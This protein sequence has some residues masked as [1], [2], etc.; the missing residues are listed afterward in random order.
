[1]TS[2]EMREALKAAVEPIST[3]LK[4]LNGRFDA[5][6]IT[7]VRQLTEIHSDLRHLCGEHSKLEEEVDTIRGEWPIIAAHVRR[8]DEATASARMLQPT[9]KRSDS[10]LKVIVPK[11]TMR[12]IPW[13]IVSILLGA[14]LAGAA[15]IGRE[16]GAAD[17][18]HYFTAPPA[19]AATVKDTE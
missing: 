1:M 5:F 14:A 10:G 16:K 4:E 2:E 19:A 18:V 17:A 11:A 6:Q 8:E 15:I 3:S 12:W 13:I 9:D 7:T